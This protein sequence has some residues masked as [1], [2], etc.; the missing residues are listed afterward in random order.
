[1]K[2]TIKQ[3]HEVQ[4]AGFWIRLWA[5]VLDLILVSTLVVV[6]ASIG[7]HVNLYLPVE[8]T[9][10][11]V[12][13]AYAVL[14]SRWKGQTIG[15][16]LSGLVVTASDGS[17]ARLARLALR[18]SVGKLLSILPLAAG[19]LW[20]GLS[21]RKRALHDYVAGTI[22]VR[23]AP[24]FGRR[25][26]I[27]AALFVTTALILALDVPAWFVM[28]RDFLAMRPTAPV[29][30]PFE[31]RDPELLT[32]AVSL[33]ESQLDSFSEWL[34]ENASSPVEYAVAKAR[35]HQV[36]VFG[37]SSHEKKELLDLL[38]ALIPELYRRT[39]ITKVALEVCLAEDNEKL[40]RLVTGEEFDRE[41]ALEIA[42]R[43]PWGVWGWK[44]YW[45]V[46][47]TVWQLNQTIPQGRNKVLVVGLDSRMDMQSL[48]MIGF[49][50]N[51]TSN[52]PLWEKLRVVRLPRVM[53]KV[54]ARD[55]HMARQIQE[56]ILEKGERA[57]VWVGGQHAWASPQAV[58]VAGLHVARMG[59][60]LRQ[61]HGEKVFFIRLHGFDIPASWVDSKYHGPEPV[62]GSQVEEMMQG[63]GLTSDGCDIAPS[64]QGRLRDTA[65][66]DYHNEPRLGLED[67]ADGYIYLR[68]WREL[69]ECTWLAGYI[70]P[71]MFV[72]NKPFYQAFGK[73]DGKLL[74]SAEAVNRFFQGQ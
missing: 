20:C 11:L 65:S 15:K 49:E 34:R 41:L 67:I 42:R 58:G 14:A 3:P 44:E 18:E 35:Q 22:V 29:V 12:W 6:V 8:L 52:C 7:I 66:F 27:A 73:K 56:E 68:P 60:L 24:P 50:D 71:R 61:R 64:P 36:L 43:Q 46:L 33:K 72:A 13:P 5:G 26:R 69:T 40:E 38:N 1:M 4:R 47:E 10:L 39:G 32:E 74:E 70:T 23:C 25:G 59:A 48:G 17:S 63:S 51:P 62:M 21:K 45:D 55:W 57:I 31:R 2:H 9:I 19:F 30:F 28:G 54:L 53:P 16:W 37:A